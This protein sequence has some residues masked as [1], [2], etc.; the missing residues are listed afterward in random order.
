MI[1]QNYYNLLNVNMLNFN[2]IKNNIY[3]EAKKACKPMQN[4]H[5]SSIQYLNNAKTNKP[6]QNWAKCLYKSTTY[7]KMLN[8]RLAD[9]H[10]SLPLS[11]DLFYVL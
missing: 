4:L 3:S 2:F 9:R 6:T 1:T 8:Y 7:T 5:Y 11:A 10:Q